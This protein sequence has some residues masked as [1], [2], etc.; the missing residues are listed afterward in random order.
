MD[1]IS[2][3]LINLAR[4][5]TEGLSIDDQDQQY[6]YFISKTPLEIGLL[7]TC[8]LFAIGFMNMFAVAGGLGG[9][10]IVIPFLMIFM[11]MPI[12]E[13][14]PLANIFAM[15]SSVTRFVYNFNQKHPYR[16]FRMIID[17][18]IVTL[19]MPMVYFGSLIGVY[20][21]SLMNQLTLVILLQIVLAFTLY[22]TFQKALQTYIKETNRRRQGLSDPLIFQRKQ[23]R[24]SFRTTLS[25][26]RLI[27]GPTDALLKIVKEEGEHFT[28]KRM[29]QICVI[30]ILLILTLLIKRRDHYE[31]DEGD[32]HFESNKIIYKVVIFCFIAS[33]LA[34]IL[35]I[36]GGIILSPVFLSLGLLPS[37]TA[38]TNQYI[39]MISTFSVSLQFIYKGQLNYS[40]A[41]VI[42]AVVLFTAIIGLSVVE[43]VVKKSG[44]QS[45]IVF[46]ISFVLLISF[47]VLPL[48]YA[49]E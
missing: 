43:R 45:I 37:V 42:G 16:P 19:T 12:Q 8:G 30:F 46:I 7:Q 32:L 34:G 23:S 6:K 14:I 44:R 47:L 1:F 9:G 25:I 35:G 13:C 33:V 48:K 41:Y 40:Y 18:E 24:K 17:Y 15:I 10:G 21:G 38:A 39:G 2:D 11:K 49:I 26:S 20:A 3:S 28:P 4:N 5:V 36:A 31:Y 27:D 22:K 29:K